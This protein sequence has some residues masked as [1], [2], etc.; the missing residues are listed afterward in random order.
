MV[1]HSCGGASETNLAARWKAKRI[2]FY[3]RIATGDFQSFESN[4]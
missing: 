4:A 2:H 1:E 3:A